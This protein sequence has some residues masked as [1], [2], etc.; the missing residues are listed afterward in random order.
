[1]VRLLSVTWFAL[2][3]LAAGPACGEAIS[4]EGKDR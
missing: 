4:F 2:L 3:L 1:M